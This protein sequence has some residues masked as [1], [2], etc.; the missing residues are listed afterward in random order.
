MAPRRRSGKSLGRRIATRREYRTVVI[1]CEGLATEHDYLNAVKKLPDVRS[2]TSVRIE[3]DPDQGAPL[4][5]VQ[6]AVRRLADKEVDAC[7]CVFDVEWPSHHPNLHQA[8]QL[9]QAN[10]VGTAISNP[11]FELWL[12][13]HH[14]DHTAFL[15]TRCANRD[16]KALDGRD[17]KHI[18]AH[19]YM[20]LRAAAVDRARRLAER[21]ARQG[22][23]MPDDNPSSSMYE[24]LAVLEGGS[25]PIA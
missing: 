3:L 15:D 8:I 10:G 13:L 2:N 16:S 22:N 23:S 9:A 11:C 1:F 7:W 25:A 24:L 19:A 14:R 21:H 6:R 20:P 12:I 17:G 4:T 18:D 5:L